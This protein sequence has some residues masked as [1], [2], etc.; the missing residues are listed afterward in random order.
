MV[1][2]GLHLYEHRGLSVIFD[3]LLKDFKL[4]II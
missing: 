1:L 3:N 4:T 2:Q